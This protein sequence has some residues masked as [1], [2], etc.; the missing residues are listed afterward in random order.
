M[1][2]DGKPWPDHAAVQPVL[3][4]LTG[5]RQ[6][7]SAIGLDPTTL[8]MMAG[9][10]A[11]PE[12]WVLEGRAHARI[13]EAVEAE[14]AARAASKAAAVEREAFLETMRV[15]TP[16]AA[17]LLV[18]R[19]IVDTSRR[20]FKDPHA[21]DPEIRRDGYALLV[22]A[23]RLPGALLAPRATATR[24]V[25][26]VEVGYEVLGAFDELELSERE[27]ERG[28]KARLPRFVLDGVLGAARARVAES[29][30]RPITSFVNAR[31]KPELRER[32]AILRAYLEIIADSFTPSGDP[33]IAPVEI[34]VALHLGVVGLRIDPAIVANEL[35][36][37]Q[38]GADVS[39]IAEDGF[40][41]ARDPRTWIFTVDQAVSAT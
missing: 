41:V 22:G 28:T 19:R 21:P 35:G 16:R 32:M 24:S 14:L 30:P 4:V 10:L 6:Q 13:V 9:R 11:R 1:M 38:R 18:A 33:Y 23:A 34:S 17:G 5:D 20:L 36:K 3:L 39:S 27:I 40:A 25:M 8:A 7:P 15:V 2:P 37:R 29:A 26:G 12:S 31:T